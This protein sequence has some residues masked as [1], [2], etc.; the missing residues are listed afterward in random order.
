MS[1]DLQQEYYARH[2]EAGPV[3][4]YPESRQGGNSVLSVIFGNRGGG[5]HCMTRYTSVSVTLHKQE[6]HPTHYKVH[7]KRPLHDG[8]SRAEA[9]TEAVW[10]RK[11]YWDQWEAWARE[12]AEANR[13]HLAPLAGEQL[14]LAAW[15][16]F[17]YSQDSWMS[18]NLPDRYK[19]AVCRSID[20]DTPVADRIAAAK[21]VEE[22]IQSKF[23]NTIG[24]FTALRT[25]EERTNAGWLVEFFR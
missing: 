10:D 20:Q 11:V 21:E 14:H 13:E 9:S 8:T 5:P 2:G 15:E 1:Q 23:R 4:V 19:D 18:Q 7:C 17:A 12:W 24:G 6:S 25:G 16:I 22:Y 3:V